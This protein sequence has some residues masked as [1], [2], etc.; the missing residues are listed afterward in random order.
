MKMLIALLGVLVAGVVNA[1]LSVETVGAVKLVGFGE[2]E[3][4]A[5]VGVSWKFNDRFAVDGR[6]LTYRDAGC[7][8]AWRS[9]VVD[10][11]GA[12]L[13]V[14]LYSNKRFSLA[15]VT[16]AYRDFNSDKW[17]FGAGPRVDFV[18]AKN[19][20]FKL[21]SEVQTWFKDENNN[22]AK[23]LLTTGGLVYSFR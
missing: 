9:S 7:N 22:R 15:T 13:R 17:G 20:S 6:A 12:L 10:E 14:T 16:G 11:A 19:L 5:G 23:S 18:I 2:R 1:Q 8:G 3:L 4:G 21:Q